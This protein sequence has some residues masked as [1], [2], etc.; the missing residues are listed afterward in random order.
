MIYILAFLATFLYSFDVIFAK[1]ALDNMPMFMFIFIMSI[2]YTI[3]GFVI[4]I[5]NY[6]YINNYFINN[7]NKK[8][9]IYSIINIIFSCIL[10]DFIMFYTIKKST[11]INLPIVISII[12]TVPILALILVYLVYKTKLNYKSII[13][14]IISVIGC[15]IAIYYSD[16]N[17]IIKSKW[18]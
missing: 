11:K 18:R 2:L 10:A 12:H 3:L 7:S 1:L 4:Y 15:I 16:D 14:I 5:N 17:I 13:G 6:K 8:Y 9:I